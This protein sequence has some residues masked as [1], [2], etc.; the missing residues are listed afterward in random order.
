MYGEVLTD[1]RLYSAISSKAW[2]LTNSRK[3]IKLVML[4]WNIFV[5]I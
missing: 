5:I 2:Q 1:C 4:V 3:C